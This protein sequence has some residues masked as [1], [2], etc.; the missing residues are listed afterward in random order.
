MKSLILFLTLALLVQNSSANALQQY[1]V[2]K[3]PV[4]MVSDMP[5]QTGHN[6]LIISNR[7]FLPEK[8]Y[9]VKRGLHPRLNMFIFMAGIKN[10]TAYVR[11]LNS[12]DEAV[13]YLPANRN[14]LVYVD[15]H[16]KNFT[17]TM[18]RGFEITARFDINMVVFDWPTDYMAL[19]KTAGNAQEVAANFVR[20]MQAMDEL[21]NTHY[22]SS[23][24]SAIFHSMGNHILKNITHPQLL[25]KMPEQLFSNIIVNAAAVKQRNHDKWLE[26]IRL[27]E[28]IYVTMNDEDRP[29]H[30]AMLL[31]LAKQLGLGIKGEK[32]E[33]A[34]YVDFSDVVSIEH[35]LFLGKTVAELENQ[36]IYRFYNQAF[37]GSEV[38]FNEL[39][40][41]HILRPSVEEVIFSP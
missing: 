22:A 12:L 3:Y 29:L 13:P 10:D 6:I 26:K 31:R 2:P 1:L 4:R 16:G 19:R 34:A 25:Q 33:N 30:G 23:R 5:G 39:T 14:F 38:I 18:E 21:R 11:V 32:A 36:Y 35:N 37:H 27:Q 9:T 20:A 28:R 24:V 7:H 8:G 17:Q 41:F 40:G 15:G